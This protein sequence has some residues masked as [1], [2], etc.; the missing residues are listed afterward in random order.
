MF[1]VLIKSQIKYL[2]Y[3]LL[4]FGNIC[5]LNRK[6]ELTDV[7]QDISYYRNLLVERK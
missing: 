1:T 6:R 2:I 5:F 7:K 4:P 3:I